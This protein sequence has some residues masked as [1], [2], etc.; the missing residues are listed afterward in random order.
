MN[1]TFL[2]HRN[3]TGFAA[4][5]QVKVSL[6]VAT[7][8]RPPQVVKVLLN[9]LMAQD[10]KE[11]EVIIVDQN[12]DDRL[13]DLTD[14]RFWPYPIRHVHTPS[15]RGLSRGRNEGLK[16]ARGSVVVFPDD[17]CWYPAGFLSKGLALLSQQQCACVTGRAV[18][19]TGRSINGRFEP[20]AAWVERSNVWTTQIE[21][22]AMFQKEPL[23]AIGGYDEA[24]GVGSSTP[25]WANEGH[26]VTL[27]LLEAGFSTYY[28]PQFYGHHAEL[29]IT[30]PDAA[31]IKKG[32]SYSRG[33]GYVL[34]RH[35]YGF[36]TLC[37]W[38]LRPI[39]GALISALK[40]DEAKSRYY[41]NIA[42]GRL[43][44]W[45]KKTTAAFI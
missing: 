36:P 33:F 44:G 16:Y 42:L 17:D 32:R 43:E 22:V 5:S 25:W 6:I 10:L 29:N 15:Q 9:N 8:G 4:A 23:L 30:T 2:Q 7:L 31:M 27:R 20:H 34:R 19:E 13:I 35:R 39:A 18:D 1:Y 28:D 26:D 24:I 3:V 41:A 40:R 45:F 38:T 37:Y 21:W 14:Q 12:N 11:F